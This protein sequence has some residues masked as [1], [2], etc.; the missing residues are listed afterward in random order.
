MP[1]TQDSVFDVNFY[2]TFY[3]DIGLLSHEAAADHWLDYGIKEGRHPNPDHY[4]A[5]DASL[6]ESL[7]ADF[8]VTIYKY[9]NGD[10]VDRYSQDWEF[11]RHYVELGKAE[12]RR[13]KVEH[14]AF[15]EALY[16][17]R[18]GGVAQAAAAGHAIYT[19]IDDLLTRNGFA[20]DAFTAKF[21]FEE[22]V[23]QLDGHDIRNPIQ[24]LRHFVQRGWKALYHVA[25]DHVFDPDFYRREFRVAIA[26]DAEC[27]RHWLT[28]GIPTDRQPNARQFQRN[29]GLRRIAGDVSDVFDHQAYIKLNPPLAAG[30]MTPWGALH[31]FIHHGV[32]EARAGKP[33]AARAADVY[34]AAADRLSIGNRPVD[35]AK[36]YET[37]LC[38]DGDNAHANQHYGDCL[39]KQGRHFQAAVA[40]ERAV[41]LGQANVWTYLNLASCYSSLGALDRATETL[42]RASKLAP[43]DVAIESRAQTALTSQFLAMTQDVGPLIEADALPSATARY[44]RAAALLTQDVRDVP[45]WP[46]AYRPIR[47]VAIVADMALPQCRFYRVQQKCEHLRAAGFAVEVFDKATELQAFGNGL[48]YFDAV[49]FYRVP[50]L[51][52]IMLAIRQARRAGIPTIYEIDDLIFDGAHYPD[53][54]E[55]YGGQITREEYGGLVTGTALFKAALGACDYALASTPSLAAVMAPLVLSVRGRLSCT[56]TP[57]A[58]R[59]CRRSAARMRGRKASSGCS[60]AP[61]PRRIT[62]IS[63]TSWV[64]RCAACSRL[65]R[66][67][68]SSS[69]WATCGFPTRW[70]RSLRMSASWHRSGTWTRTG[71]P[72]HRWT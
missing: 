70:R 33:A 54:L 19:S 37:V 42:R 53:S 16:P 34:L 68:S 31:H 14:D 58:R 64:R 69:S 40:Y 41:A 52:D 12:G 25:L 2:R 32:L 17:R 29:L 6:K 66:A 57:S 24:A 27:Y 23:L 18:D 28:E 62:R 71:A 22:Y 26:D 15:V 4:L 20:S 60:T 65:I 36:L 55:S 48:P 59:T 50:A 44:A 9:L 43:G 61:A 30:G 1:T 51:P 5:S 46:A 35:A 49:I 56:G 72:W 10:L 8:S 67:G 13:H 39:L 47:T 63:R 21:R 38:A 45:V 7:P 11:I 3:G